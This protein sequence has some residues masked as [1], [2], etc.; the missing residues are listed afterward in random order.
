MNID[1]LIPEKDLAS[2]KENAVN[3]ALETIRN[4]IDQFGVSEPVIVKQGENQILVQLPGRKGPA[5]G[6]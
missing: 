3:Q 4:R 2:I 6:A 5:K 1:F